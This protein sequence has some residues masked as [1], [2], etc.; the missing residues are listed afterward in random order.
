MNKT[1]RKAVIYPDDK[2][3]YTTIQNPIL[4]NNSVEMLFLNHLTL[5]KRSDREFQ[6]NRFSSYILS[7]EDYIFLKD[8]FQKKRKRKGRRKFLKR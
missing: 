3:V 6:A 4:A 2:D 1:N 8:I 7:Y 5:T